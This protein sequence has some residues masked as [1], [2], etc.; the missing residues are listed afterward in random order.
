MY[1]TKAIKSCLKTT[2][3]ELGNKYG[4]QSLKPNPEIY[5]IINILMIPQGF[6]H[7]FSQIQLRK[8]WAYFA[9]EENIICTVNLSAQH[10]TE[11]TLAWSN[12]ENS[13]FQSTNISKLSLLQKL[14]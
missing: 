9:L 10:V 2:I 7:A 11:C 4:R 3:L 12:Q 14:T 1:S 5:Q 13:L 8:T 6:F